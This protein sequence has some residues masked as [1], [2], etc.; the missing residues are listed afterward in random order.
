VRGL[1]A[2]RLLTAEVVTAKATA[3]CQGGAPVLSGS[4]HVAG[5]KLLGTEL[6]TDRAVEQV[7]NVLGS[8]VI[9]PSKLDAATLLPEPLG[10]TL[11]PQIKAAL[12]ALPEIPIPSVLADVR[13]TPGAQIRAGDT[14]TQRALHVTAAIG[15]QPLLDLVLGEAKASG[16]GACFAGGVADQILRCTDRKLVLVDVLER[17]GRVRLIGAANRGYVGRKVN[18]R[19]RATGQIVARPTVRR[20]GSFSAWAKLPPNTIRY[21]NRARYRAEI[22][23][24]KSLPLKLHRR[25]VVDRMTARNGKVTIAGRV[26]RP[27]ASPVERITLKRRVSCKRLVV[28]KRFHPRS[29]GSF[30]VTVK[31]PKGRTAAVYRLQTRVRKYYSNPKT[32]PTFTLP[33]GVN[34]NKR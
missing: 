22:R 15:G 5:V 23:R 20:D 13:I 27:L 11:A 18:I 1:A 32:Y 7:V 2:G 30:R 10:S 24:E 14:L 28:V 12:D 25:M 26:I 19:L 8:G 34:L 4:S 17:R 33:R 16:S 9:D 21:T 29:D 3:A 6:P 31:A